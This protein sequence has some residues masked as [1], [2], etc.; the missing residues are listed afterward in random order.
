MIENMIRLIIKSIQF[1]SLRFKSANVV[2]HRI[3]DVS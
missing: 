1:F 2:K 3:A